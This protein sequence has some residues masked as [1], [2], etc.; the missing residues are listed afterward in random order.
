MAV[1][2]DGT[3]KA[4]ALCRGMFSSLG[5]LKTADLSGWDTSRATDMEFM[6]SGCSSLISITFGSGW[7]TSGV[8]RARVPARRCADRH[9]VRQGWATCTFDHVQLA[10]KNGL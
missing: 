5:S 3:V 9:T 4:P 1:E 8:K 7:V 6:F 2:T 10:S